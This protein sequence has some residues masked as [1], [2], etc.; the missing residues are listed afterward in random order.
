MVEKFFR[1]LP[2]DS[3]NRLARRLVF[4]AE[5]GLPRD[6]RKFK[7]EDDGIFAIKQGQVRI[8]CFLDTGRLIL[9]THGTLKKQQK[10]DPEDLKRAKRLRADYLTAKR[11]S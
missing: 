1:E 10:A 2:E 5:Q 6:E 7:H 9:L 3:R 4:M 8:Y 11:L